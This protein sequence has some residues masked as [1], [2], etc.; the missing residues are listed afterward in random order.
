MI[1][2]RFQ[3]RDFVIPLPLSSFFCFEVTKEDQKQR[4]NVAKVIG[5]YYWPIHHRGAFVLMNVKVVNLKTRVLFSA[6]IPITISDS[7]QIYFKY[8]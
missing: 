3:K 7:S 1:N 2:D 8:I 6:I 5:F 4:Y